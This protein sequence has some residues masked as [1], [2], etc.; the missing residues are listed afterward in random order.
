MNII[1]DFINQ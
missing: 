1:F